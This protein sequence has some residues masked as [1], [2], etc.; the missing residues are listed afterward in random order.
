MKLYQFIVEGFQFTLGIQALH[1][2]EAWQ[3]LV[4]AHPEIA[5]CRH[6]LIETCQE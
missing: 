1:K 4:A 3:Q 2:C 5:D 6:F